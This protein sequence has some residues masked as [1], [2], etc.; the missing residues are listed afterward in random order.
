[1][2]DNYIKYESSGDKN[3]NLSV[4]EYLDKIKSYLRDIIINLQKSDTWKIQLAISIEFIS[5][6][7]VDEKRIIHLKSNNKEFMPYDN[8]NEVVNELFESFLSRYQIGLEILMKG[9][10]FIF[11]SVELL[12]YKCYK[13]SLKLG[14]SY[15]DFPDWIKNKKKQ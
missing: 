10:N 2:S 6:K 3:K 15:I 11:D 12:C 13:I 7:D 14:E 8:T 5:S 9:S 4:K 1:M